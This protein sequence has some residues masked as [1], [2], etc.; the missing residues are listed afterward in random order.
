M[1]RIISKL[2]AIA[3]RGP[4]DRDI[5]DAI[6]TA[7]EEELVPMDSDLSDFELEF[8]G[9]MRPGELEQFDDIHSWA[10][11]DDMFRGKEWLHRAENWKEIPP[12]VVVEKDGR[13]IIGDG[14]GRITF[15]LMRDMAVPT[16]ILRYQGQ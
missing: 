2:V 16:W 12:I 10:Q 5:S 6:F 4:S 1:N 15:A 8:L 9:N 3:Y 7:Q 11:D 14:R 13:T